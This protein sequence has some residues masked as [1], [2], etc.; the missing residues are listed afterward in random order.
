M[1]GQTIIVLSSAKA[2]KE[3]MDMRSTSTADR[4]PAYIPEQVHEG[5]S[6]VLGRYSDFS[7]L[8]LSGLTSYYGL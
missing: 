3:L 2:V 6:L 7:N 1:G 4:P 5:D 8:C